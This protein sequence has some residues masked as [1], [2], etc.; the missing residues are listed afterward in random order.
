MELP[1][2]GRHGQLHDPRPVS[3]WKR[4]PRGLFEYNLSNINELMEN[5]TQKLVDIMTFLR[6]TFL[7]VM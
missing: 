7:E 2:T 4:C 3:D 1:R 6:Y 5:F